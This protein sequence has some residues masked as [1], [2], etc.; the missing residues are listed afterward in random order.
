MQKKASFTGFDFDTVW[1]I[2]E[3]VSTPLLRGFTYSY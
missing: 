2:D 3:G 1:T